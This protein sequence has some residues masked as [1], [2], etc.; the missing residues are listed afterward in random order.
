MNGGQL[1]DN[2]SGYTGGAI[3]ISAHSSDEKLACTFIMNGGEISN[4]RCGSLGGAIAASV[5]SFIWS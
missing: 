2:E 5:A 4:N 1:V 3:G